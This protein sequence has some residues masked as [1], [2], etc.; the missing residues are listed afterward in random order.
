MNKAVRLHVIIFIRSDYSFRINS[1]VV[2]Y[3][4]QGRYAF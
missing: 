3:K 2:M 1:S 4:P